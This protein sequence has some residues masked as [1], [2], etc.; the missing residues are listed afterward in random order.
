MSLSYVDILLIFVDLII[1][2]KVWWREYLSDVKLI[3]VFE[4]VWGAHRCNILRLW[5]IWI[6]SASLYSLNCILEAQSDHLL[7]RHSYRT[8]SLPFLPDD[9]YSL[10]FGLILGRAYFPIMHITTAKGSRIIARIT[11]VMQEVGLIQV[12]WIQR[13]LYTR[14]L[15]FDN[16][17]LV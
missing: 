11:L 15:F 5:M 1:Y 9:G 14:S 7:L 17:R 8:I 3:L 6:T 13:C 2:V 16:L 12:V 4:L 10:A